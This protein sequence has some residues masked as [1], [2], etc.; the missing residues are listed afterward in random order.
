MDTLKLVLA[1]VAGLAGVA[2][3]LERRWIWRIRR[4]IIARILRLQYGYHWTRYGERHTGRNF[5]GELDFKNRRNQK[6]HIECVT[7]CITGERLLILRDVAPLEAEQSQI[8]RLDFPMPWDGGE[9]PAG[10][11]YELKVK[12]SFGRAMVLAGEFPVNPE[13]RPL[14]PPAVPIAAT[15]LAIEYSEAKG[16]R[17]YEVG[18]VA[19]NLVDRPI[20]IKST[21]FRING[22]PVLV[23]KG[24]VESWGIDPRRTTNQGLRFPLPDALQP[25]ND[26]EFELVIQPIGEPACVLRGHF[27]IP[28]TT[29]ESDGIGID[30]AHA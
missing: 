7:L 12:P 5:N 6:V 26:G 13:A 2:A 29:H 11:R 1:I 14:R 16:R 9:P 17:R 20:R 23:G 8:R 18:F 21:T 15:V 25:A 3:I 4:P 10:A 24:S 27:P 30:R 22:G 28:C 19:K